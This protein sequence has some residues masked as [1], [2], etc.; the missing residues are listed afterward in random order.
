MNKNRRNCQALTGS[1]Q[2][3]NGMKPTLTG[4]SIKGSE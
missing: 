2:D 1:T 3:E 4:D